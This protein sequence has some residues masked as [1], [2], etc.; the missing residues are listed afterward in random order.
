MNKLLLSTVSVM[1]FVGAAQASQADSA[2]TNSALA[3]DLDIALVTPTTNL[4]SDIKAQAQATLEQGKQRYLKKSLL[5]FK[6]T[7]KQPKRT[8]YS[9]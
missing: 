3:L 9:E 5:A 1:A 2:T 4:E 7:A 8:Q 6:R